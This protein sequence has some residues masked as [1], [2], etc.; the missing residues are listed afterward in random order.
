MDPLEQAYQQKLDS[1][2]RVNESDDQVHCEYCD[3]N[4]DD[5]EQCDHDE[6][7]QHLSCLDCCKT[8]N[9][10]LYNSKTGDLLNSTYHA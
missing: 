7:L 8:H 1:Y 4:L 3:I 5:T 6:I 2:S 10:E 9:P